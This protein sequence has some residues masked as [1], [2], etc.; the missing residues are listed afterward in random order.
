MLRRRRARKSLLEFVQYCWWRPWKLEIGR[1]TREVCAAIDKGI[2]DWLSGVSSYMDISIPFRHGKSDIVSRALPAYF[3]G[4]C[5]E[6]HPDVIMSGYGAGLVQGFSKDTKRIIRSESYQRLFPA[7]KIAKGE[8]TV[9]SWAIQGSSGRVTATGLGGD[10]TGKG[11]A[12]LI[13]DDYCKSRAEAASKTYRDK[14]WDAFSND[15][16]TRAAPVHI[17]I[18]CATPWHVDDVRGRI[19]AKEKSDPHF[20]TFKQLRFPAKGPDGYLFPERFP[21]RWYQVQYAQL[22]KLAAGLL[23]CAPRLEGGN[24]FAVGKVVYHDSLSE[25]PSMRM[26]R[27]WDLASS[28]KERDKDDPDYTFGVKGGVRNAM[29]DRGGVRV[30]V[31]ELWIADAV[32]CQEEAPK[33]DALIQRTARSDG[34]SVS[35]HVEAFG[36]YKDAYTSLKAVLSGICRVEPSRLPG[37]KSAKLAPLEPVFDGGNVHMLRAPWNALLI[38]HFEEFP[39]G[40]HDDGADGTSIVYH[41]LALTPQ[42]GIAD[43]SLIYR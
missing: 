20:P 5:Y 40:A 2:D 7:V 8:D 1:H 3:L 39:D 10:L 43:P 21:E 19:R 31:P 4:R 38:Q 22:G 28:R 6:H 24:R 35:Q 33:R 29:V 25:F 15:F 9:A 14:T 23:D 37:D 26:I 11:G 16:L 18:V 36:G 32:Y 17:V 12:L 30:Q 42:G 34:P 27:G 41:E 13:L